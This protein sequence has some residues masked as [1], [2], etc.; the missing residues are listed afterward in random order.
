MEVIVSESERPEHTNGN[1]HKTYEPALRAVAKTANQIKRLDEEL[2]DRV[3]E[4]PLVAVGVALAAGY[5]I[6]RIFS[7][8]G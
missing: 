3:R 6:G 8:W 4:K 5:V 1:S 2:I 7:R